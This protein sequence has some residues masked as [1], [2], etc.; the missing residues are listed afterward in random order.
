MRNPAKLVYLVNQSPSERH[1]ELLL[2]HCK[3]Q[4]LNPARLLMEAPTLQEFT[5]C[6]LSNLQSAQVDGELLYDGLRGVLPENGTVSATLLSYFIKRH[7]GELP[8]YKRAT[9]SHFYACAR[10]ARDSHADLQRYPLRRWLYEAYATS[11]L[12]PM[13]PY[14]SNNHLSR[15]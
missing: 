5:I 13:A 14:A 4:D 12:T 8:A 1:S 2:K 7:A 3:A 6:A 15:W 9:E 10:A 11:D